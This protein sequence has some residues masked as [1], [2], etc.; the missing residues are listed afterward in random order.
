MDERAQPGFPGK[1]KTPRYTLS[2]GEFRATA[3][4]RSL[5]SEDDVAF[6]DSRI[7]QSIRDPFLGSIM[8]NPDLAVPDVHMH[9]TAVNPMLPVPPDSHQFK[10]ALDRIDDHLGLDLA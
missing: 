6:G 7:D 9:C 1:V 8:L 4:E 5:K 2:D 3:L 10:M